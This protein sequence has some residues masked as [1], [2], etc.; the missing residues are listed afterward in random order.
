MF[1]GAENELNQKIKNFFDTTLNRAFTISSIT[2]FK[3]AVEYALEI[4]QYTTNA[5]WGSAGS[6]EA[7]KAD[8]LAFIKDLRAFSSRIPAEQ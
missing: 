2:A 8:W 5:K 1:G 4:S 3:K 7:K 6:N